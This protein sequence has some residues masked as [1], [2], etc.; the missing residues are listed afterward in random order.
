MNEMKLKPTDVKE[1]FLKLAEAFR[2]LA[3]AVVIEENPSAQIP[4]PQPQ[5]LPLQEMPQ[6]TAPNFAQPQ[7]VIA[8]QNIATSQP[9][10]SM[11]MPVSQT[12]V[13]V[14]STPVTSHVPTTAV[15]QE[16]TQDQLAVACAG[17]VNQ[18]KQGKLMQI[19]QSFGVAALVDVP[20]ERYGE[21]AII[22]RAEGAVI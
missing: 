10:V 16:Y 1:C 2:S 15:T 4:V 13:P 11:Q 20:K 9:P 8:Q 12:V 7:A 21:L 5:V 22:L 14:T 17:L 19:L 18:G 3:D 6:Y